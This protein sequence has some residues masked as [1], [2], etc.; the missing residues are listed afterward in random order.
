[1]IILTKLFW[2]AVLMRVIRTAAQAYVVVTTGV[3]LDQINWTA[4]GILGA[5]MVG[6]SIANAIIAPPPEAYP[7][8]ENNDP[9]S[10]V[11][12]AS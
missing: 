3:S 1:M 5:G 7:P 8:K 10:D 12:A 9:N 4:A 11:D 2:Q 6:A